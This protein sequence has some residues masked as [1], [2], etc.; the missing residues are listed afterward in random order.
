MK[1]FVKYLGSTKNYTSLDSETNFT[2]DAYRAFFDLPQYNTEPQYSDVPVWSYYGEATTSSGDDSQDGGDNGSG[3]LTEADLMPMSVA[4]LKA[5]ISAGDLYIIDPN[6][7]HPTSDI[8]S[9][10]SEETTESYV[11]YENIYGMDYSARDN[12]KR[13]AQSNYDSANAEISKKEKILDLQMTQSNTELSACNKEYD[14]AKSL[15]EHNV[16]TG[17]K[18]F[19]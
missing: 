13:K 4:E 12:A 16:E 7:G 10:F 14:S 17:F 5:L 2:A 3:K 6:T 19:S 9:T 15:I 8:P 11:E 18:M 1:D